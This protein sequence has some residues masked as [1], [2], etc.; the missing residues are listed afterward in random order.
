MKLA[1]MFSGQGSQY[2]GMGK[3]F[4]QKYD[5]VR[6]IFDFAEKITSYPISEICFE[7]EVRLFQ[8]K[9]TQVCMFTLYQAILAVLK[10]HNI[11]AD[12]SMGLSLGEYGAYLHNN[13]FDFETGLKIVKQR[14]LLME[15]AVQKT[16]GK[17]S[18]IIGLNA[19]TIEEIIKE[20]PGYVTIANYNTY[21]QLVV[22]GEEKAVNLLNELAV[23]KGA[24]RAILLSTTGAFHSKMMHD[25]EKE[26]RSFLDEINLKEPTRN[27]LVNL[28]GDFHKTESQLKDIFAKQ[29]SNSVKFYQ[30]VEQL[31]TSGVDTFIE[32]GPKKTLCS[33]V[34]KINMEVMVMNIEDDASL[35]QTLS[36]MEENHG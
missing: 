6:E 8:T 5:Y 16:S 19:T 36:K 17:M 31:I 10:T 3:E 22:S 11:D 4:Y 12:Y 7:D 32:I 25:A 26:F 27:L 30:M 20:V 23:E 1:F 33:F 15:N 2:L 18:A 28:T 24:K 21:D 35:I 13:I 34:K 29:L 14:A 9:Y